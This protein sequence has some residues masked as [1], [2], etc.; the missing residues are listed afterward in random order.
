MMLV[1]PKERV[2]RAAVG[3]GTRRTSTQ[4]LVLIAVG[5]LVALNVADLITT[6]LDL[7]M[8]MRAG[9]QL[10]EGNPV[11]TL[12]LASGKVAVIKGALLVALAWRAVRRT[13]PMAVVCGVWMVVGV[14]AM[15]VASNLVTYLSFRSL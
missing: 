4:K 9:R 7:E 1:V 13:P 3:A 8:S 14:Y 2:R 11:A 12:L 10:V 5:L 6:H 15:T